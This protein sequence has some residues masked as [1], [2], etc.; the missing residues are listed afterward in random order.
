MFDDDGRVF[1]WDSVLIEGEADFGAV[2]VFHDLIA[3]LGGLGGVAVIFEG[4]GYFG[5]VGLFYESGGNVDGVGFNLLGGVGGEEG[6]SEKSQCEYY[7]FHRSL[8]WIMGA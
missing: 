6:K 5:A 2:E 4:G 7:L 8:N 1:A 3:I